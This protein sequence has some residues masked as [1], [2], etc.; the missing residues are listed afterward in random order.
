M[1]IARDDRTL[2]D[3]QGRALAGAL[4]YW[5]LQPATAPA[6]AP[7]SPLADIFSDLSGTP[8]DQPFITDGF[9]HAWAY[10]DDSPLY[11]IVMYHSLFGSNPIVWPDQHIGGGSGGSTVTA[12]QGIPQGTIDGVNTAFTVVNGAIPLTAFPTQIEVWVNFPLING[13]GYSL[14]ISGGGD[15]MVNF[16][17]PPQPASGDSPAD[18]LWAQGINIV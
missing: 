2:T 5:C 15:L 16:A 17:Q 1:A 12:F 4:V 6:V 10:M 9:G 11:T 18:A 13:L 3:A 7:P 14:S 8:E